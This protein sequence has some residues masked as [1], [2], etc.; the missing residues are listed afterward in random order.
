MRQKVNT[1]AS[2]HILDCCEPRE[3]III[4][5]VYTVG[6]SR[7][8]TFQDHHQLLLQRSSW[9][10]Y[11]ER[12]NNVTLLKFAVMVKKLWSICMGTTCLL[13]RRYD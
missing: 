11:Q 13:S 8:R 12:F 7:P 10:H 9:N 2:S 4:L 3:L 6:H 1:K 5:V